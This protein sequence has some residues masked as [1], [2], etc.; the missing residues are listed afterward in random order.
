MQFSEGRL[1]VTMQ[2]ELLGDELNVFRETILRKVHD[3]GIAEVIIDV[4]SINILDS[5]DFKTIGKI[6]KMIRVLGAYVTLVG[7]HPGSISSLVAVGVNFE[8]INFALNLSGAIEKS[9]F[10]KKK[11]L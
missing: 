2:S 11:V 1:I 8:G 4:S 7:L 10:V 3:Q 9:R 5:T 6:L